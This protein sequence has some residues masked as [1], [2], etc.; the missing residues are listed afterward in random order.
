MDS[1]KTAIENISKK[2]FSTFSSK[3]L[4]KLKKIFSKKIILRDW[5]NIANGVDEVCRVNQKIFNSVDSIHVDPINIYIDGNIAIGDLIIT[6]NGKESIRVVDI[7][8]FDQ[9]LNIVSIKAYKG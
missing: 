5:E 8:E 1:R 4:N 2:Y 7:L 3:D 6:I 9:D